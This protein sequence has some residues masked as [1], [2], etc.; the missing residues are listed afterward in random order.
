MPLL[1]F[2]WYLYR[3]F[4]E[5]PYLSRYPPVLSTAIPGWLRSSIRL[6]KHGVASGVIRA[7]ADG[8]APGGG[9][10]H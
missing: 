8:G 9:G 4:S 7:G 1:L 3:V 10:G 5:I 6:V 2:W